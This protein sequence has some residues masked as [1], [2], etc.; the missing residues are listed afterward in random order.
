MVCDCDD[1]EVGL[2]EVLCDIVCEVVGVD[3]VEVGWVW[4]GYGS[5]CK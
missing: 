1:W 3:E 5:G 4:K 2:C